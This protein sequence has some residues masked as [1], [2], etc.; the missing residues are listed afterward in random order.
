MHRIEINNFGPIRSVEM[1]ITRMFFLLGELASGKSTIAKL[2][3]FFRTAQEEF[4]SIISNDFENWNSCSR[5][6]VSLLR[7]KFDNIF[8]SA[9]PGH[10][11]IVY[12]YSPDTFIKI[13]PA[14]DNKVQISIEKNLMSKLEKSWIDSRP[15][16]TNGKIKGLEKTVRRD[17]QHVFRD[18]FHS[19]YIPAGRAMLSR[20]MLLRVILSR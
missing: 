12:H 5:A 10:F 1:D 2:V 15:E 13:L 18:E 20:Q 16:N 7:S 17:I 4:V 8:G 3:Y 19:I 11:E 6:Y 14:A 9:Y